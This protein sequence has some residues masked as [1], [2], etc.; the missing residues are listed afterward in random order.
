MKIP[1]FTIEKAGVLDHQEIV[2]DRNEKIS[3]FKIK[4]SCFAFTSYLVNFLR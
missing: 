3:Q 4:C 1:Y 2:I